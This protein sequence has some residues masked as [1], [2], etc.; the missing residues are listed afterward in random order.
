M[1]QLS[2]TI[3]LAC[4]L[5]QRKSITP[6]DLGC[7]KILADLLKQ[8]NFDVQ[9]L[10]FNQV[11][12]FYATH[13]SGSP[14][15]CFAGHTDVVPAG[16]ESDWQ[17]PPF[18]AQILDKKLYGRGAADMKGS[19]AA[20]HIAATKFVKENPNHKG[21]LSLLITSDEEGDAIDGTRAV[22]EYLRAKNQNIDYCI[23]GEPSS[24]NQV[25]D[26]IKNGRRGSITGKLTIYGKQGHVAYPHL[27]ANPINLSL[28]ALQEIANFIWDEGNEFFPPTSLQFVGLQTSSNIS[29]VIPE[30]LHAQFNLRFNDLQTP[31]NIKQQIIN[32]LQNHNLNFKIDWN[33]SGL[34]FIT[35]TGNLLSA[36][37][38]S[39]K[40]ITGIN[41]QLS[42]SGGTS[43]GRFI[44]TLNNCQVIE[45]GPIN[46]TIHQSNEY[47][48][49]DDLDK[50]TDIYYKIMQKMLLI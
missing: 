27:A 40:D 29:N 46:K 26:V 22:I 49:I 8:T 47:V 48:N 21:T 12:N 35:S 41:T 45:L 31:T 25:G 44:S 13:G 30:S 42:T 5:L 17:H 39:I 4:E 14:V 32:I 24:T 11:Q 1:P 34:P 50:L 7:Q 37:K 18:A 6:Q 33:L 2:P 23:V 36:V 9:H 15:L 43:D 10:P 16:N 19:L 3:L 28:T 20:M 38:N